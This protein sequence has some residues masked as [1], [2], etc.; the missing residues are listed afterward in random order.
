MAL[1]GHRNDKIEDKIESTHE[2]NLNA[3]HH[4]RTNNDAKH[5]NFKM[6]RRV[7]F[8][9]KFQRDFLALTS[10]VFRDALS[11][12]S[13]LTSLVANRFKIVLYIFYPYFELIVIS[14]V[15]K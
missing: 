12:A 7:N 1:T 9:L 11:P 8:R 5:S 13:F 3:R 4:Q 10:R 6:A 2:C 15:L 14:I